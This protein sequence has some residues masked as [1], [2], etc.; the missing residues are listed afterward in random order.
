MMALL[1]RVN[2]TL[3]SVAKPS[4]ALATLRTTAPLAPLLGLFRQDESRLEALAECS[5][6]HRNGFDKIVLASPAGTA[7]KLVLH[8]WPSED[9]IDDDDIHDHRWDFASVVVSGRL[10]LEMYQ[11]DVRGD[12]FSVMSYRSLPGP[13]NCELEPKGTMTVSPCVSVTLPVGSDY[14]WSANLLHRAYGL[15]GH[16]TA[17][18][19][20]QGPPGRQTTSVLVPAGRVHTHRNPEQPLMRLRPDQLERTL[21]ILAREEVQAAWELNGYNK[22]IA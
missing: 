22:S 7:L 5:Y 9:R 15:P 17:T 4:D 6:R 16:P 20:V 18:L 14:S 19:I 2:A 3:V 8:V 12:S 13:G 10:Q 21:S 1:D 11:P